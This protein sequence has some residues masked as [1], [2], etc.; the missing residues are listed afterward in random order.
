[1]S[2]NGPRGNFKHQS[3]RVSMA[4][5]YS[6]HWNGRTGDTKGVIAGARRLF[7]ISRGHP[8][9]PVKP[10]KR[11]WQPSRPKHEETIGDVAGGTWEQH[12]N[13]LSNS[14]TIKM[15]PAI[16]EEGILRSVPSSNRET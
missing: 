7:G 12:N 5:I 14:R 11:A 16:T 1:M 10:P 13:R 15:G 8:R 3:A 4:S 6:S 2:P 9:T